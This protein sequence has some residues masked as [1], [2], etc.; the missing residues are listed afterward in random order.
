MQL[1]NNA[2]INRTIPISINNLDSIS[3]YT[4]QLL[5]NDFNLTEHDSLVTIDGTNITV[6]IPPRSLVVLALDAVWS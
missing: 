6:A 1:I 3:N 4:A 2:D 5:N